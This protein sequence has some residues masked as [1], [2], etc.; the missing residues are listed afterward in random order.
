MKS[1]TEI[2]EAMNNGEIDKLTAQR[3]MSNVKLHGDHSISLKQGGLNWYNNLANRPA[4]VN[5]QKVVKVL[6][7]HTM[8]LLVSLV[9]VLQLY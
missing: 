9:I 8:M 7:L 2:Y 4:Q 6:H 5:L 1:F 3:A